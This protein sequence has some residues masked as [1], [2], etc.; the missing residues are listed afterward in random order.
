VW[1]RAGKAPRSSGVSAI[2]IVEPAKQRNGD[3]GAI[4]WATAND[5][6]GSRAISNRSGEI[7]RQLININPDTDNREMR[8]FGLSAHFNQ[9]PGDFSIP[10]ENIVW[11]LYYRFNSELQKGLANTSGSPGGKRD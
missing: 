4:N 10:D 3:R 9:E 2:G 6:K 8:R 5:G 1:S 11:C 7:L